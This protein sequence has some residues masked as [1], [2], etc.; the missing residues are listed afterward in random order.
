MK[1]IIL[2]I[3]TLLISVSSYAVHQDSIEGK[4]VVKKNG[5]GIELLGSGNGVSLAYQRT[6]ITIDQWKLSART[7][8]LYSYYGLH[9]YGIALVLRGTLNK[10]K[11]K[12]FVG[13]GMMYLRGKERTLGFTSATE[14][15]NEHCNG[16]ACNA[17]FISNVWYYNVEIG[18]S[19]NIGKSLE[20][21]VAYNPTLEYNYYNNNNKSH[22]LVHRATLGMSVYF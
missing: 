2:F 10:Y 11:I 3:L 12:P 6:L 16:N 15:Y 5:I 18:V 1:S 8:F 20:I 4:N 13:I 21:S 19:K 22:L 14:Y 7:G 17:W 9:D